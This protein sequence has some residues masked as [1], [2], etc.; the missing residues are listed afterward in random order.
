MPLVN[1]FS[2][3][4]VRVADIHGFIPGSVSAR[5]ADDMDAPV[6]DAIVH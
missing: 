2:R 3:W 1:M 4:P 5:L 6:I